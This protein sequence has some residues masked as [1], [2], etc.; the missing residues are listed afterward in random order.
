MQVFKSNFDL[1]DGKQFFRKTIV[2][3]K[4]LQ[5]HAFL[6]GLNSTKFLEIVDSNKTPNIFSTYKLKITFKHLIYAQAIFNVF[7]NTYTPE[8]ETFEL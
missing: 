2:F 1:A 8:L 4:N 6:N 5:S 7:Q 3:E